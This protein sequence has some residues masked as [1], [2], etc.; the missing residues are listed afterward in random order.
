[1]RYLESFILKDLSRKMVLVA[2]PRQCGKTTMVKNLLRSQGSGVYLNWDYSDDQKTI[3]KHLWSESDKLII[4]D[5]LHKYPKWKNLLKGYYDHYKEKH[6]FLVTGSARLD[7]YKRGGDSM[8][9]R[10]HYYRLHPFT[11]DELP[12]KISSQDAFN[13]LMS[14]GGFPE[15]FLEFDEREARRWREERYDRIIRDDIRDLENIK[16]VQNMALLLRLLRERVGGTI[17]VSNLAQDLKISPITVA[18]WI[19]IFEKMYLVFKVGAYSKN[20]PRALQKPFK[21]YFFDN[22]DVIGD[23]GAVF[24]NLCANHLLKRC[25]FW[26]DHTGEQWELKFLRDKEG[27]EVDFVLLKDGK[28]EELI[29]AKFSDSTISSGLKYFTQRLETKRSVQIVAD[30]KKYFKKDGYEC[31]HP[32]EYFK[33]VW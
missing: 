17:V 2:G 19:D 21:V 22:A 32:I 25:H 26:Q 18:K 29:E 7:V 30:Q 12:P 14:V 20:L 10:Y 24:E 31:I 28:I 3:L 9:G 23:K 15:P 5:E 16:D 6:H 13:R 8:L 1:M 33:K 4:F 11:L 27:H